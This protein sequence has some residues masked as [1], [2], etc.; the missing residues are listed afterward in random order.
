MNRER[1]RQLAAEV[2]VVIPCYNDEDTIGPAV[3]SVLDQ[4]LAVGEIIVVDDG[5]RDDSARVVAEQF[6]QV[7]LVRQENAGAAAARN[8]GISRSGGVYVALLDSDDRWVP[9]KIEVQLPVFEAEPEVGIVTAPA[10]WDARVGDAAATAGQHGDA[11]TVRRMEDIFAHPRICTSAVV[12]RRE[13]IEGVGLLR[14]EL[15]H[16]EDLEYY[17]RIIASGWKLAEVRAPLAVCRTE[18]FMEDPTR[19][20]RLFEKLAE[21]RPEVITRWSP[22]SNPDSPLS[23]RQFARAHALACL[24][25]ANF[26]T[27]A[28]RWDGARPY[29][30]RAAG[31]QQAP[32]PLRLAAR[33]G[34]MSPRLVG[35]LFSVYRRVSGR[36]RLAEK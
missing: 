16:A 9:D 31:E 5:S 35:T 11:Y 10:L 32:L 21:R 30:R 26:M 15:A 22:D 19:R 6:P 8:T 28:G 17:L 36:R 14:T 1:L 4:T 29:F 12:L 3:Q 27:A 20:A 18:K 7:E 13:V 25:S 33:L 23:P 34:V 24:R 2:S